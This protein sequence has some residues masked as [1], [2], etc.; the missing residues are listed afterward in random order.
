MTLTLAVEPSPR[1]DGAPLLADARVLARASAD[2][3]DP[4]FVDVGVLAGGVIRDAGRTVAD[5]D[6]LA[7]DVGPGH[8]PPGRAGVAHLNH[9]AFAR[10]VPVVALDSLTLL[11]AQAGHLPALVLRPAGGNAVYASLTG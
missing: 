5:L 3:G 8:L 2:R 1:G 4:G 9:G 11:A 10:G 6:R 7:A